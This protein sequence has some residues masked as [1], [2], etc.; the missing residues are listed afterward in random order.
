MRTCVL[1]YAPAMCGRYSLDRPKEVQAHFDFVDWHERRVEPRFNIA[2]TQDILTIVQRADTAPEA[3]VASW[4]LRPHWLEPDG[5][6]RPPINARAEGI[7]SSGLFRGPLART[8]C[9]IPATGFYEWRAEPGGKAKTPMYIQLT[10]GEPFAFAG[11]WLPGKDAGP[12]TA[13]IITTHANELMQPIHERMPVILAPEDERLWLDPAL[14]NPEAVLPL[15]RPYP[16]EAMTAW[17]VR[18]LVNRVANDGPELL[19]P[20]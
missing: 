20:A 7:A 10:A 17:A 13:A 5:R 4:G 1:C 9:L 16:S 19:V 14:T 3:Q 6:R 11:L 18:P 12:P 15:L 8:R 2:P